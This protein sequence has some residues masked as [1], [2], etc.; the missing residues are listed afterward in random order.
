MVSIP[1][2][3]KVFL[4]FPISVNRIWRGSGRRVYKSPL[5]VAWIE[6]VDWIIKLKKFKKI[7]GE[8]KTT[9]VLH[10][11]DKRR[12][13][14]DNFVKCL[15]DAAQR[16]GLIEDDSF[17]RLL[18]VSYDETGTTPG[19]LLILESYDRKESPARAFKP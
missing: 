9:I 16:N 17:N 18:L 11:P 6:E 19:V 13:D 15:L 3:I 12:R 10:P 1:Q 5:Y 4:P 2:V 14:L 8:F 7:T